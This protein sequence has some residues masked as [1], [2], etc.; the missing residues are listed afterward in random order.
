MNK[1]DRNIDSDVVAGFGDEWSRFPQSAVESKEL[2]E[3]FD[4]YFH[5]FPW[6]EIHCEESTGAD[7]GCGSGRWAGFVAERVGHLHAVDASAEALE[8][9]KNHCKKLDNLTYHHTG[10]DSLPFLDEELDFAYSLGVLHHVPETLTA[11]KSIARKMKKGAPFL[12]YLYYSFDNRSAQYR[13]VWKLSETLRVV[14]SRLPHSIRYSMSQIFACLLYYPLARGAKI[15][16]LWGVNTSG[17][18]LDFYKDKSFYTMRTDALDRFGTRLEQRFSK[19]EIQQMLL[20]A[21]FENIQ[22][23]ETPPYWCAIARRA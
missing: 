4:S 8:V 9:A 6:S 23:S 17:W 11:L 7:I 1:N 10:V 5:I 13:A 15:A 22:F 2:R 16:N 18:P 12:I 19:R 20:E 14:V 21:G 3:L